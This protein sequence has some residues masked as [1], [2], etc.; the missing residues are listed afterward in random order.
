M[1]FVS[2][3]TP[4]QTCVHPP[5]SILHENVDERCTSGKAH[6]MRYET[7]LAASFIDLPLQA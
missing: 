2:Y 6:D 4:F 3:F 5:Y 7:P 1:L